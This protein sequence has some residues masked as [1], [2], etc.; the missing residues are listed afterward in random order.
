MTP[1]QQPEAP[2]PA[3]PT[4]TGSE[5]S[6]LRSLGRG[7]TVM[8]VLTLLASLYPAWKASRLDPVKLLKQG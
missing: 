1:G 7:T 8:I 2:Q 4:A 6:L 5:H 3:A